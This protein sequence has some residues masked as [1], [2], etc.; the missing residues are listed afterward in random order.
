MV[1][2]SFGESAITNEFFSLW[3]PTGGVYLG[4]TKRGMIAGLHRGKGRW[5][6]KLKLLH[7][8]H[9]NSFDLCYMG[10]L[11]DDAAGCPRDA[12]L[13]LCQVG[14]GHGGVDL[15]PVRLIFALHLLLLRSC[16][17]TTATG[18]QQNR[19]TCTERTQTQGALEVELSP[20]TRKSLQESTHLSHLLDPWSAVSESTSRN[21][22]STVQRSMRIYQKTW[23]YR[24]LWGFLCPN[25]CCSV[26]SLHSRQG[27]NRTFHKKPSISKVPHRMEMKGCFSWLI[28]S[29][30]YYVVG[31][32]RL[33]SSVVRVNPDWKWLSV[34]DLSR[35]ERAETESAAEPRTPSF[36]S[37]LKGSNLCVI[38]EALAGNSKVIK[39]WNQTFSVCLFQWEC[40]GLLWTC[41]LLSV[42]LM[43]WA[44]YLMRH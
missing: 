24:S 39:Q 42:D 31:E 14:Q 27:T 12:V 32:Q 13:P 34:K 3:T 44:L 23:T 20:E 22:R 29:I 1:K 15:L 9:F 25:M 5:R 4:F 28:I 36:W 2:A 21:K 11:L 17:A 6:P 26:F 10:G 18:N 19:Q 30:H 37:S 43:T 35:N 7:Q 38:C 33:C 40:W 16:D 8:R 41:R